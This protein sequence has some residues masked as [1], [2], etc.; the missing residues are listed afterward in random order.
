LE[1]LERFDGVVGA[2]LG[3]V[4]GIILGYLLESRRSRRTVREEA[5]RL[6]LLLREELRDNLQLAEGALTQHPTESQ[7]DAEA[8]SQ[9]L[10]MLADR[11]FAANAGRLAQLTQEE[12]EQIWAAYRSVRTMI[13]AVRTYLH[14]LE[15]ARHEKRT[16]PEGYSRL[17]PQGCEQLRDNLRDALALLDTR[18]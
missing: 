7:D 1:V 10:R 11:L 15:Q 2:I 8:I 16:L 3:A 18:M 4:V 14:D 12:L 6:R 5:K 17:I 13:V 9:I